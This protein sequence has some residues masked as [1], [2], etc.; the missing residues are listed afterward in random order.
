VFVAALLVAASLPALVAYEIR[1][2]L[3]LEQAVREARAMDSLA[4]DRA[5][6]DSE[7]HRDRYFLGALAQNAR[8]RAGLLAQIARLN[9]ADL[10]EPM[11]SFWDVMGENRKGLAVMR[12]VATH[13]NTDG[14]TLEQL[15][16][17]PGA[18]KVI[19]EV[20]ANPRTPQAVLARY[21]DST[22]YL[23]QWGLAL[24]P[25]TPQRVMERLA[26]SGNLYTRLNLTWNKATPREIL[27]RLAA[28]TDES[29]ARNAK[30]AIERRRSAP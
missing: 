21:Y 8:A 1:H 23:A 7:F 13:P 20:L 25:K 6:E 12:L 22:D 10:Y 15:A 9:D 4:L 14:A 24:N 28:D 27:E 16:A 26:Q 2:G 29:V 19:H 17:G 3:R 18:Q 5:F 11:G 30:Q